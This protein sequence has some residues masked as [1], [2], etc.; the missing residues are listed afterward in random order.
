MR[1]SGIVASPEPEPEEL[2]AIVMALSLLDD[3]QRPAPPPKPSRWRFAA[4]EYE[5]DNA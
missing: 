3:A 1:R 5:T 2:A 4:R